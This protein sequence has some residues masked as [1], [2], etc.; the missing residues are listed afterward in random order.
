MTNDYVPKAHSSS[1]TTTHLTST[2][3]EPRNYS[4]LRHNFDNTW[5]WPSSRR[6]LAIGLA[7][8]NAAVITKSSDFS[9]RPGYRLSLIQTVR[10]KRRLEVIAAICRSP[11]NPFPF[12]RP[13]SDCPGHSSTN[14]DRGY[15]CATLIIL[16]FEIRCF[17][18]GSGRSGSSG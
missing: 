4:T 12:M 1:C 5:H 11:C 6:G 7:K 13:L 2:C 18:A 10:V 15:W 8:V 9:K 17:D 3:S 16:P 14:L